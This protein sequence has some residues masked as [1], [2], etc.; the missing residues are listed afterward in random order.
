MG[1]ANHRVSRTS[2]PTRFEVKGVRSAPQTRRQH[3][4]PGQEPAALFLNRADVSSVEE[5]S[6][7]RK[8]FFHARI[9]HWFLFGRF[10]S[11]I[12]QGFAMSDSKIVRVIC[13]L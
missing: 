5:D 11:I 8:N 7:T 4:E 12:P 1:I 10:T 2:A 9:R 13:P 6:R 3:G